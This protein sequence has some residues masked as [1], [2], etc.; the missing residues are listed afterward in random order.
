MRLKELENR[1]GRAGC[2]EDSE[3]LGVGKIGLQMGQGHR[4]V[5]DQGEADVIGRD[6]GRHVSPWADVY[7]P[8]NRGVAVCWEQ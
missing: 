7:R 4:V 6:L 8:R 2:C 3:V 1:A 5:V